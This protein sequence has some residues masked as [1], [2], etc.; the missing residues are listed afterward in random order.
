MEYESMI[1]VIKP[2]VATHKQVGNYNM[3]WC[4]WSND[5]YTFE[6]HLAAMIAVRLYTLV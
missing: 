3:C 1:E 5:E 2:E 6:D 4:G